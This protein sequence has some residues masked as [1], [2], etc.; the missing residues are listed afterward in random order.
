MICMLCRWR[1]GGCSPP[2]PCCRVR[3]HS[4]ACV[5]APVR[6]T[7]FR[8]V[9]A[10]FGASRQQPAGNTSDQ[11][12]SPLKRAG[13]MIT[14]QQRTLADAW[15]SGQLCGREGRLTG[16]PAA[17]AMRHV[18]RML[19]MGLGGERGRERAQSSNE[20]RTRPIP[21]PPPMQAP[22]ASSPPPR[23]TA[24]AAEGPA[25]WHRTRT[26]RTS[27]PAHWWAGVHEPCCNAPPLCH[28]AGSAPTLPHPPTLARP[29]DGEYDCG[30]S[31]QVPEE[32]GAPAKQANALA[33]DVNCN[34]GEPCVVR[35][36]NTSANAGAPPPPSQPT[37]LSASWGAAR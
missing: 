23:W 8:S 27:S 16:C 10:R 6:P 33:S 20:C 25:S 7:G 35:T 12:T 36:A 34:C 24:R 5:L 26:D 22:S 15:G 9:H 30:F 19:A 31:E 11:R 13:A 3:S 32:Q 18:E 21:P 17:S 1:A 28:R 4:A 37:R 29:Q 2:R 14:T